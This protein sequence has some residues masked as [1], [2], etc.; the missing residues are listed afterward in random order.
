MI[1]EALKEAYEEGYSKC[2]EDI[3]NSYK[4]TPETAGEPKLK[5]TW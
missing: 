1:D 4:V 2:K 3:L 5:E